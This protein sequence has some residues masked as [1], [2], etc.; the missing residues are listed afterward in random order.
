MFIEKNKIGL[1]TRRILLHKKNKT[2]ASKHLQ[3]H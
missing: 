2:K 1:H 3:K